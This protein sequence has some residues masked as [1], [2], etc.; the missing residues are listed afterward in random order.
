MKKVLVALVV[1]VA[2]LCSV[3]FANSVLV[4]KHEGKFFVVDIPDVAAAHMDKTVRVFHCGHQPRTALGE[5][6]RRVLDKQAILS[7]KEMRD[8]FQSLLKSTRKVRA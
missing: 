5:Y 6:V 7:L 1:L 2:L 4:V 8:L 3:C